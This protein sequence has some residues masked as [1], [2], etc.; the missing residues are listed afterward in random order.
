MLFDVDNF[1]G[2]RLAKEK[3]SIMEIDGR[4]Y[5]Y[6]HGIFV[7]T[8]AIAPTPSQ[9]RTLSSWAQAKELYGCIISYPYS[10]RSQRATNQVSQP[11]VSLDMYGI[12]WK[13]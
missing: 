11:H 13:S 4:L 3:H 10:Q 8:V 9:S 7:D 12:R 6:R 5:I 2:T 1:M